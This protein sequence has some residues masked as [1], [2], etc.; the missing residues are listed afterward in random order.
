MTSAPMMRIRTAAAVAVLGGGLTLTACGS[1]S[2]SGSADTPAG[3]C[4]LGDTVEEPATEGGVPACASGSGA[5]THTYPCYPTPG[6]PQQ[7]SW[8][9]VE[10]SD[11][12][13]LYG[14]PGGEWKAAESPAK[15]EQDLIQQIGC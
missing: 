9:Q 15:P 11:D 13:V 7:G 10:Y 6:G 4:Q 1:D 2:S 8:Y 14:K 3:A 12:N 5:K